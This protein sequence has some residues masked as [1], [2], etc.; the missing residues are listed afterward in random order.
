MIALNSLIRV[1]LDDDPLTDMRTVSIQIPKSMAVLIV[2]VNTKPAW[3]DGLPIEVQNL[4]G[5]V[6]VVNSEGASIAHIDVDEMGIN[7]FVGKIV[8]TQTTIRRVEASPKAQNSSPPTTKPAVTAARPKVDVN[9]AAS[10][11]TSNSS[12]QISSYQ[13]GECRLT[14]NEFDP[15][16]KHLEIHGVRRGTISQKEVQA[17]AMNTIKEVQKPVPGT[18]RVIRV[19]RQVPVTSSA[20]VVRTASQQSA[21]K[22][23]PPPLVMSALTRS[24]AQIRLVQGKT[25]STS[26]LQ[27]RPVI[28]RSPLATQGGN[29]KQALVTAK[30]LTP[31]LPLR[32]A[33]ETAMAKA[34]IKK[35]EESSVTAVATTA[36]T[37]AAPST[38]TGA[39][40]LSNQR[41]S[42]PMV[43]PTPPKIETQLDDDEPPAHIICK[44]PPPP[45]PPQVMRKREADDTDPRG[46]PIK[47]KPMDFFS[48]D[49]CSLTFLM[50]K[51]YEQHMKTHS[52]E[53][54]ANSILPRAAGL[55][56]R[57]K[58]PLSNQ[59]RPEAK[60]ER[61]KLER[62]VRRSIE[63]TTSVDRGEDIVRAPN[64]RFNF[65]P[66]VVRVIFIFSF[67]NQNLNVISFRKSHGVQTTRT[68]A[69]KMTMTFNRRSE[70]R[71]HE[72]RQCR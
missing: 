62:V 52:T 56:N 54:A 38:K 27:R 18:P 42:P 19:T 58:Q 44:P 51:Y 48:C 57:R 3:N 35:N 66:K 41:V 65:R 22:L 2:P 34:T 40:V 67:Y 37:N 50:E 46:G 61:L 59:I 7:K 11:S 39:V 72:L 25:A 15:L 12:M 6:A 1:T 32:T 64:P 23:N 68:P 63:P 9:M 69:K 10:R 17:M 36:V 21:A 5:K 4:V 14:F 13:C 60:M 28:G 45:P 26:I 30:K 20:A 16:Q 8:G 49:I 31:T 55:A 70:R 71:F 24:P 53:V 29:T 43:L 47:T 33:I